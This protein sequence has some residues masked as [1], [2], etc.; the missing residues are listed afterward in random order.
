M[1]QLHTHAGFVPWTL[2]RPSG[3][4]GIWFTAGW[5]MQHVP[6]ICSC[7][8]CFEETEG[9]EQGLA[10]WHH[11]RT[12]SA[13]WCDGCMEKMFY[14]ARDN[15]DPDFELRCPQCRH[16]V[17]QMQL[18]A[19]MERLQ[20][21]DAAVAAALIQYENLLS[22]T[23]HMCEAQEDGMPFYS[24]PLEASAR[25]LSRDD[26]CCGVV[27]TCQGAADDTRLRRMLRGADFVGAAL[28]VLQGYTDQLRSGSSA[29]RIDLVL[30]ALARHLRD[31]VT[32][33]T[34]GSETTSI[35]PKTAVRRRAALLNGVEAVLSTEG[36]AQ[37]GTAL[38]S[39]GSSQR[40]RQQPSEQGALAAADPARGG[41]VLRTTAR[42]R[43]R[44]A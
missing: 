29:A 1:T 13:I 23:V 32:D 21:M 44:G 11:C 27:R 42:K 28:L 25:I 34:G 3:G 2:Q 26:D 22:E 39:S 9:S 30:E 37:R 40:R 6:D 24:L 33:A 4:T 35:A 8:V 20:C 7:I 18:E 15:E 38:S 12:C 16:G 36:A 5:F 14:A 41:G 43:G 17:G 10:S 31:A 19:R